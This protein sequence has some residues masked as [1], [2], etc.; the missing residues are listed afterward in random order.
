MHRVLRGS[1]LLL[2]VDSLDVEM[3]REFHEDDVFTPLDPLTTK[4]CLE[5]SGF[6]SVEVTTTQFEMRVSAT[7]I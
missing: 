3:I 7:R 6:A 5:S 1:G 4:G 2:I